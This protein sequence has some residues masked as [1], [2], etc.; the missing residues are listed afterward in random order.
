MRALEL[1]SPF[2]PPEALSPHLQR[3]VEELAK[4]GSGIETFWEA[5]LS[6][7]RARVRARG[8]V[9][10]LEEVLRE[11]GYDDPECAQ[12]LR[13]SDLVGVLPGRPAWPPNVKG[14]ECE[15][16]SD[17]LAASPVERAR[18]WQSTRPS[19]HDT[20]LLQAAVDDV[21]DGKMAGPFYTDSEVADFFDS[22]KFTLSKRFGVPQHDKTRP[23][24]DFSGSGVNS[25]CRTERAL[26]LSTLDNFF[27]LMCA[28]V[29]A[30]GLEHDPQPQIKFFKRDMLSAYR[31][32]WLLLRALVFAPIIFW[33]PELLCPVVFV[34]LAL[35]FGPRASVNS[36]NRVA[37]GVTFL[38]QAKFYLPVDSYFD[39]WW[40]AAPSSLIDRIFHMFAQVMNALGL[41]IK[42]AKDVHPTFRGEIL[43]HIANVMSVPFSLEN[44]PRR[45][46]SLRTLVR[47]ALES[48]A[49]RPSVAGEIAGKFG[50]ACTAIYGRVGRACL[51]PVYERQHSSS[52]SHILSRSLRAAL[53]CMYRILEDPQ[54]R[55]VLPSFMGSRRSCVAYTDGQGAGYIAAVV[56]PGAPFQPAYC[57]LR[58]PEELLA[59]FAQ[60]N[61]IQ[62]IETCAVILL[63]DTFA[64]EIADCDVRLF[65]DNIAEQGALIK[66]FSRS[67]SQAALCGAVW[68]R[69]AHGRVGLWIDR[70]RSKSNIADIPTRPGSRSQDLE[71]LRALGARC[72]VPP[73]VRIVDRIH[74]ELSNAGL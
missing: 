43:G 47:S 1:P 64:R 12:L 9:D 66:G 40:G 49:L 56:F 35:P 57:S 18:V 68:V 28:I 32:I 30:F 22:D 3:A 27:A 33:H 55:V 24:D 65:C 38:M 54:P 16:A 50:F 20:I 62:Q 44:T 52:G 67:P 36:F 26:T 41:D 15:S 42:L 46:E 71:I 31:Q 48:N 19:P 73:R 45:L 13:G 70:V 21:A 34:H 59:R 60:K 10:A 29:V 17:L 53:V 51:K 61:C 37:Q 6:D 58:L 72:R 25:C 14:A 23:C 7:L 69:A 63:F 39:D 11:E 5:Q 2:P 8:R 74:S 4:R